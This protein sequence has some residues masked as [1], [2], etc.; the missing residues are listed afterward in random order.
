METTTQLINGKCAVRLSGRFDSF[1]VASVRDALEKIRGQSVHI[2]VNLRNVNFMDSSAVAV[3]VQE[4]KIAR[5]NGGD[6]R[7]CEMQDTVKVIF[8]LTRL[9]KAFQIFA[10]EAEALN[11]FSK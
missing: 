10:T 7:L 3:L 9:D 1:H 5:K 11:S 6:V 2:V 8:D 4:M